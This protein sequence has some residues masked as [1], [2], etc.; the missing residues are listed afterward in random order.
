MLN[1]VQLLVIFAVLQF[2]FLY[3]SSQ[4]CQTDY[5][6][7]NQLFAGCSNIFAMLNF[8]ACLVG[9]YYVL[10]RQTTTTFSVPPL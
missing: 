7:G 6:R 5:N 4:I 3:F 9:A 8:V 10:T 2:A 1:N